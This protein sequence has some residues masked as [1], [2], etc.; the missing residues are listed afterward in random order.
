MKR[1]A[2]KVAM[3]SAGAGAVAAII[4]TVFVGSYR[5]RAHA[6]AAGTSEEEVAL[7]NMAVENALSAFSRLC[8]EKTTRELYPEQSSALGVFGVHAPENPDSPVSWNVSLDGFIVPIFGRLFRRIPPEYVASMPVGMLERLGESRD[9][10]GLWEEGIVGE[11]YCEADGSPYRVIEFQRPSA[12]MLGLEVNEDDAAQVLADEIGGYP[13]VIKLLDLGYRLYAWQ[14]TDGEE[15]HF[16]DAVTGMYFSEESFNSRVRDIWSAVSVTPHDVAGQNSSS[17]SLAPV[18]REQ[19]MYQAQNGM[20]C[21][22]TCISMAFDFFGER[23]FHEDV[24]DVAMQPG[25]G[26]HMTD[27]SRAAMFS[28]NSQPHAGW[29]SH[30]GACPLDYGYN[31]RQ[32]GYSAVF[33]N[34]TADTAFGCVKELTQEHAPILAWIYPPNSSHIVIVWGFAEVDA[35]ENYVSVFDPNNYANADTHQI[36]EDWWRWESDAGEPDRKHDFAGYWATSN[37]FAMLVS[38]LPVIIGVSYDSE[39][40]EMVLSATVRTCWSFPSAD[41]GDAEWNSTNLGATLRG[42]CTGTQALDIVVTYPANVDAP[43][44]DNPYS[45]VAQ[46]A[47]DEA[48]T[49]WVFDA[50]DPDI[51]GA[52]FAI[53]I[54]GW[55]CDF[56][57]VHYANQDDELGGSASFS[58]DQSLIRLTD[59]AGQV[60]AAFGDEGN[61][62]LA[63]SLSEFEEAI[64]ENPLEEELY[65][66]DSSYDIVCLFGESGDCAVQALRHD[67]MNDINDT[68]TGVQTDASSDSS[69]ST[70]RLPI[71]DYTRLPPDPSSDNFYVRIHDEIMLVTDSGPDYSPTN[72]RDFIS[73]VR[74][75]EGTT[76]VGHECG[77]Q[78]WLYARGDLQS[79]INSSQ[80]SVTLETGDASIFPSDYLLA[81][82]YPVRVD[83]EYML[84]TALSQDTFTVERG[85][86]SSTAAGHDAGADMLLVP[87]LVYDEQYHLD[88]PSGGCALRIRNGTGETVAYV[89]EDGHVRLRGYVFENFTGWGLW[90]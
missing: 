41:T 44:G 50:S 89:D 88:H 38:P 28:H 65:F 64:S 62:Y 54:S 47:D 45:F 53:S 43:A 48:S 27:A 5:P 82:R 20:Q 25:A 84:V 79:S 51:Y 31:E 56:Y 78:I 34:F 16:V 86:H 26:T 69:S 59:G 90:Q 73:V 40:N 32:L 3:L 81:R 22:P 18:A 39:D 37:Y 61:L 30:T 83:D 14:Y 58:L 49:S 42:D 19:F 13:G 63:G 70:T 6:D 55:A 52:T 35:N 15:D 87:E 36:G 21:W 80:T 10:Y 29:C 1:H 7:K 11:V 66:T 68:C 23:I 72:N 33:D 67:S 2:R 4:L 9:L 60:V 76:A 8:K 85:W 77:S 75:Q 17:F 24:A 46:G 74:G 57:L 12:R 71:S